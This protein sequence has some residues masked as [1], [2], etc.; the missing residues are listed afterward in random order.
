MTDCDIK[1]HAP[2]SASVADLQLMTLL[3][4]S[5]INIVDF[6]TDIESRDDIE[7][8]IKDVPLKRARKSI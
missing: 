1:I 6:S 7:V 4:E 3:L 8:V 2:L 5:A